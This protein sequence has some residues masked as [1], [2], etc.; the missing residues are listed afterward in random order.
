MTNQS[1]LLNLAYRRWMTFPA[2]WN[3]FVTAGIT[4]CFCVIIHI[5]VP[6]FN[7]CKTHSFAEILCRY[8]CLSRYPPRQFR[9]ET[10]PYT[11][12]P[13]FSL[14]STD[15]ETISPGILTWYYISYGSTLSVSG[16]NPF[17]SNP[18]LVAL[19]PRIYRLLLV[20]GP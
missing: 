12:V 16:T 5:S 13:D 10:R 7:S 19:M 15:C 17:H 6:I 20:W 18:I 4:N 11:S 3:S 8:S 1:D 14:Y 9:H 2:P